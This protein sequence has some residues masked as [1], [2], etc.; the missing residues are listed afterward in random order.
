MKINSNTLAQKAVYG[1]GNA[2]RG[3]TDSL[4]RISTGRR[5]NKASDD[6]SG[7]TIASSLKSKALAMGQGVKNANDGIS[8]TQI[9]DGALGQM[10]D[11]L[12][13]VRT[14][15]VQAANGSQSQESLE[16]IQADITGSLEAF[17]EIARS[18]SFNGQ[19]L[20]D[21]SFSNKIFAMG[22][23]GAIDIS[24]QGMGSSSLGSGEEGT[25]GTINVTTPEG[26]Q[27]ALET[28]DQSLEQLSRVRSEVGSTQNQFESSIQ[29]MT[30]SRINMEASQSQ[31]M[32]V[33]LAEESM[34]MNQMKVLEKASIFALSQAN[35]IKKK[36]LVNL[37]G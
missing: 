37:L 5:I 36:S 21:G 3:L 4:E 35:E 31:I 6:A 17:D 2:H 16:A 26:A 14:Q 9:A 29:N 33:D 7:M 8:I 25:L 19:T 22:E 15:V 13:S 32:D 28:I 10:T 24:I 11:I 30:A 23:E 27:V 12:Q 34:V 18:T 1:T 20:L